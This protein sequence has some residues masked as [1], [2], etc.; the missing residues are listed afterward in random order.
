[1]T[2]IDPAAAVRAVMLHEP[3]FYDKFSRPTDSP[4][5]AKHIRC[6]ECHVSVPASGCPTWKAA[7]ADTP[8]ADLD[9]RVMAMADRIERAGKGDQADDLRGM[10]AY[11]RETV[12]GAHVTESLPE[13]LQT[14]AE[15]AA[16]ATHIIAAH[17]DLLEL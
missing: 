2:T 10:A 13:D 5:K 6:D 16:A 15:T 3:Q 4:D 17:L 9:S 11:I 8:P 7:T 14:L 12:R 1:M